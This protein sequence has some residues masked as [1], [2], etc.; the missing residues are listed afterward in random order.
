MLAPCVAYIAIGLFRANG[1]AATVAGEPTDP[2]LLVSWVLWNFSGWSS[3]G[4]IAGE[5][6]A[7]VAR[8]LLGGIAV[9]VPVAVA[10]QALPVVVSLSV[11]PDVGRCQRPVAATIFERS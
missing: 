7:P 3:F 5:V 10:L 11:D 1:A 6:R 2:G 8:T 4:S 9:L